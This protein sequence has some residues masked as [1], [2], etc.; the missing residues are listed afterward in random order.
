MN[1]KLKCFI[2]LFTFIVQCPTMVAK[3]IE[4]VEIVLNQRT[5][6]KQNG[7]PGPLKAPARRVVVP[8]N[9]FLNESNRCIS[10]SSTSGESAY[11]YITLTQRILG[12]A[13]LR[14]A[15]MLSLTN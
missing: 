10:V 5:K 13:K 4:G 11:Y 9:A 15:S 7:N 6:P 12:R 14:K 1:K 2:L 8:I 3:D